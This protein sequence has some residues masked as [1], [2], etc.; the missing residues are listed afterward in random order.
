MRNILAIAALCLGIVAQAQHNPQYSLFMFNKQAFNPAYV[1]AKQGLSL[2]ADYRWQWTGFGDGAPETFNFGVHTPIMR[3]ATVSKSSVGVGFYRDVIGFTETNQISLQY[4]YRV[5]VFEKST[6]SF[7]VQGSGSFDTYDYNKFDQN[8]NNVGGDPALN[9]GGESIFTPNFGAG[10]YLSSDE[11]YVG[12]SATDLLENTLA[13]DLRNP[14]RHYH[15]MAGYVR[16][17]TTNFKLRANAYLKYVEVDAF[18]SPTSADFNLTGIIIDR[19]AI[20]ASYRTDNTLTG[21]AHAQVTNNINIGYAYDFKTGKYSNPGGNSHELF[22][23]FDIGQ[24]NA[25]FTT[26]RFVTLF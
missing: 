19:F 25:K 23:G 1:G 12:L 14:E 22:I 18:D 24:K 5:R 10:L 8:V 17:I 9:D 2:N 13:E 7:G 26:P 6:L 4:A 16:P 20:G 11:Y 15:I 3:G 21:L